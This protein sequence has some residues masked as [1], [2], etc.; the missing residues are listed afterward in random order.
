MVHPPQVP[1][2]TLPVLRAHPNTRPR[3]ATAARPRPHATRTT[4][5]TRA[6]T[7]PITRP[8]RPGAPP[9]APPATA[10]KLRLVYARFTSHP[11]QGAQQSAHGFEK[12]TS[13]GGA[14]RR[15]G[16][17]PSSYTHTV[18]I[19]LQCSVNWRRHLQGVRPPAQ[20]VTI[21]WMP[22][23]MRA[24]PRCE[25]ASMG[26]LLSI[27]PPQSRNALLAPIRAGVAGRH[28]L[29]P[30]IVQGPAGGAGL[31]GNSEPLT[32]SAW[33]ADVIPQFHRLKVARAVILSM[34]RRLPCAQPGL[35]ALG[36]WS[37][38]GS[39]SRPPRRLWLP[40]EITPTLL[41]RRPVPSF[42]DPLG[43]LSR[44]NAGGQIAFRL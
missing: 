15:P 38:F 40:P 31:E 4:A 25:A 37:G 27:G 26:V 8:P 13:P 11:G 29:A 30:D 12:T 23:N 7:C 17:G 16:P 34:T 28:D 39:T 21:R 22:P 20:Q 9:P 33:E 10:H 19:A 18:R 2:P 36:H 6:L 3:E 1:P 32:S 44:A 42:P 41:E 5:V 35:A 14:R 24:L 43:P